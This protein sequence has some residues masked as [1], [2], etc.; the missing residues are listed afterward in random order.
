MIQCE[1]LTKKYGKTNALDNLSC[2]IEENKIIGLIGRNG[3]GKT[4]LLKTIAGLLKPTSGTLSVFGLQPFGSLTVAANLIFIDD[5]M[6]FPMGFNLGEILKAVSAFYENWD[7][8]FAQS[9]CEYFCID[10]KKR[11][12]NLSKGQKST[13]NSIIGIASRCPITLYDEPTTGMDSA[14]RKDFYRALLKDYIEHPR[15]IILSSHL[16]GEIDDILEDILLIKEGQLCLHIAADELKEYAIGLRGN[17][18]IITEHTKD[19]QVLH[20]ESLTPNTVYRVMKHKFSENQIE[21]LKQN[22]VEFISVSTD[23]VCVY[24]TAKIQGG[25]DNVFKRSKS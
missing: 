22:G 10:L 19:I 16:L 11:H 25:I 12:F 4:T 6:V 8:S 23:D 24:L 21:Q 3:A 1:N 13:F 17:E 5:N 20:E 15:T 2:S 9:L 18:N 14:V 7:M